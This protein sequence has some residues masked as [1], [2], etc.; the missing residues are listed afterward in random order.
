MATLQEMLQIGGSA[1]GAE[2]IALKL[3]REK[4]SKFL[5]DLGLL[6]A[7]Q[8]KI[9][10]SRD[11][12]ERAS[13][14]FPDDHRVLYNRGWHVMMQ[15]DL[16]GGFTL[17]NK[18]RDAG[19]WGS[20]PIGSIKPIW[21][22]EDINGKHVLFNCEAGFGDQ[23]TFV[24]FIKNIAERG[25]KVTAI[26]NPGLAP[27]FARMPE[28]SAVA[29]P[30]AALG[31]YHDYW[32]PS[33]L[34]PVVLKT[35]FADLAGCSYLTPNPQYVKKFA[36]YIN[37]DKLKVGLRW[38]GQDG[39]NYC[40]RIFPRELLFEA[41]TQDHCQLYSLQKD[42]SEDGL[43]NQIIDLEVLLETWED[44]AGAIANLDLVISSCTSVA[45]LSAAMGKETWIIPPLM[46]YF[47]WSYPGPKSPWYDSVTLFR[48]EKY[49]EWKQP[50]DKIK[51]RLSERR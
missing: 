31:V 2:K 27:I 10:K 37:S 9:K 1:K 24:R 28:V 17:I 29:Q 19:L 25:A 51:K 41:A 6:Y 39:P 22:S 43:P 36:P 8:G 50:F 11:I 49:D 20:L 26:C 21:N 30:E 12:C 47:I 23:I 32:I 5:L 48:Q 14:V 38:L 34:V 46:F 33:M 3:V 7:L 42:H 44:T 40:N 18:G 45:H 15:G 35:Q 13:K 4:G 16:L